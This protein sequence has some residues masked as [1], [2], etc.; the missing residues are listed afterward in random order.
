MGATDI[1][2]PQ[3]QPSEERQGKAVVIPLLRFRSL[4]CGRW[5]VPFLRVPEAARQGRSHRWGQPTSQN[6]Q[7]QPSEQR[8]PTK[9]RAFRFPRC[10]SFPS[11]GCWFLARSL[12]EFQ[13]QPRV[14]TFRQWEQQTSQNRKGN[15][16][17]NARQ[18]TKGKGVA[19]PSL[20]IPFP[21]LRLLVLSPLRV[22]EQPRQ[23][24]SDSLVAIPF[25]FLWLLARSLLSDQKA[26]RQRATS[27]ERKTTHQGKNVRNNGSNRHRRTTRATATVRG[28]DTL[29]Q[30]RLCFD[31]KTRKGQGL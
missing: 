17:R 18:P 13:K 23:G 16:R 11:V 10:D 21:P 14:K 8:T 26:P 9:A 1:T 4:C 7:R 22:P 24:R 3:G 6:H 27:E 20:L 15:H 25:P 2:E 5:L 12:C 31:K 19:I 28:T 30:L 29:S